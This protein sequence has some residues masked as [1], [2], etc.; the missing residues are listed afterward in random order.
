M[1]DLISFHVIFACKTGFLHK[2]TNSKTSKES[3]KLEKSDVENKSDNINQVIENTESFKAS[4]S[5]VQTIIPSKL[6]SSETSDRM[7]VGG[8]IANGNVNFSP[9]IIKISLMNNDEILEDSNS[10]HSQTKNDPIGQIVIV[11]TTPE[12]TFYSDELTNGNCSTSEK[13]GQIINK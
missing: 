8:K 10:T 3:I 1:Y 2:K 6:N 11:A 5:N 7:S 9:P 4:T 13:G 12:T